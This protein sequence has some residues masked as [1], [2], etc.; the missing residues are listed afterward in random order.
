MEGVFRSCEHLYCE[1]WIFWLLVCAVFD[2]LVNN[3]EA[4]G[5][6]TC[7]DAISRNRADGSIF[8]T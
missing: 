7:V 1:S 3:A 6:A 8:Q 4:L 5:V 2:I